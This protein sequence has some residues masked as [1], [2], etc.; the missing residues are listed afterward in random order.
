MR[1]VVFLGLL[2]FAC[3]TLVCGCQGGEKETNSAKPM[4]LVETVGPL[5]SEDQKENQMIAS[6]N[7]VNITS[8]EVDREMKNLQK[9]FQSRVPPEQMEKM[10]PMLQRQALENRISQRL[11]LQ[12]ADRGGYKV[13]EEGIDEQMKNMKS[14]FPS[15]EAFDTQL[16]ELGVSEDELRSEVEE[17]MMI[18]ALLSEKTA[19]TPEV[20][21][22]DVEKFYKKNPESFQVPERVRASH[23]LLKTAPGDGDDVRAEKRQEL[24]RLMGE[25]EGGA[26]FDKLAMEHS[27]CPSKTKGGD[28]GYF[29]RG[30]MDKAFEDAAFGMKVDEVSDIV[31][32]QFGYHLIKLTAH[33]EGRTIPIDEVRDKIEAYLDNKNKEEIVGTLIRKLRDDVKIDYAEGYGPAPT[34]Q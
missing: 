16:V 4:E 20:S 6:V 8:E 1:K 17:S 7:G 28:L 25:I 10:Q 19:S 9:Q 14:R 15:T 31:E 2:M 13:E 11:L 33:E 34:K 21:G 22:E 12:E 18:D 23:I 24:S 29:G 5:S 26:A 27:E 32:S 30:K 3:G